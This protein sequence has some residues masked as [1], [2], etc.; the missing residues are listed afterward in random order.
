[1][2]LAFNQHAQGSE[3]FA[4]YHALVKFSMHR[5]AII[6]S[7]ALTLSMAAQ[8]DNTL[9]KDLIPPSSQKESA[10]DCSLNSVSDSTQGYDLHKFHGKVIYVDF[11]ASWC[12]P[13]AKSFPFLNALNHEFQDSGLQVL[14]IN[15]DEKLSDAQTFLAKHPT[16]FTVATSANE[17]CAKAFGLKGMPTSYLVD[18]NGVIR[19]IHMGFRPGEADQIRTMVQQLLDEKPTLQ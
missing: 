6:T 7:I 4:G 11:W 5:R 9:S 16:H 2:I 10:P 14:G 12:G 18:R 1:V 17:Q 3:M 13:C 8:G 15:L 19:H